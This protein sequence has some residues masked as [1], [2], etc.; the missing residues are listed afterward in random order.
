[1]KTP[2]EIRETIDLLNI[3][4][5]SALGVC[6]HTIAVTLRAQVMA[7]GYVLGEPIA[8]A[9]FGTW[10]AKMRKVVAENP[11]EAAATRSR[12]EQVERRFA[13]KEGLN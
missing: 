10:L 3:A 13:A 9:A 4:V 1:M 11:K 2:E 12:I 7:L 8:S 5:A 6:D